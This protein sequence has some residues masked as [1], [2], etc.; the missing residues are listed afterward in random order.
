MSAEVPIK[1]SCHISLLYI[2]GENTIVKITILLYCEIYDRLDTRYTG[3]QVYHR[4]A[5]V[6]RRVNSSRENL[7]SFF[8][9]SFLL[10]SFRFVRYLPLP[11][12]FLLLLVLLLS[13]SP[14]LL[15]TC[16][17]FFPPLSSRR[18]PVLFRMF[19]HFLKGSL[20]DN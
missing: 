5:R 7:P 19:F 6:L 20:A 10:H 16:P 8:C 18:R 11:F 13:W 14:S 3:G 9:L 4:R 17:P 15:P 12:A 2:H 1:I